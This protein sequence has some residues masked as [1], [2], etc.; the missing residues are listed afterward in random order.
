MSTVL[1]PWQL[2]HG[3]DQSLQTSKLK[4]GVIP[5]FHLQLGKQSAN[6]VIVHR[7]FFQ[8]NFLG[9]V[10]LERVKENRETSM[11]EKSTILSHAFIL[12]IV[13]RFS[14]PM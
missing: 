4:D 2:L 13:H 14:I 12:Y 8:N 7:L 11:T 5:S 3:T 1:P 9:I 6:P 10:F